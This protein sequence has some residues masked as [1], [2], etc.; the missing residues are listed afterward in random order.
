VANAAGQY[1]ESDEQFLARMEF[2]CFQIERYRWKARR[3]EGRVLSEDE[4]A[5]E[6][7]QRYAAEFARELPGVASE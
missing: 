1:R 6:W 4:A 5:R 3:D 2:Q 7:I